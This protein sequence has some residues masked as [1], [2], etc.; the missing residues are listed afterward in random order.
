MSMNGLVS[1]PPQRMN[2]YHQQPVNGFVQDS[3]RGRSYTTNYSQTGAQFAAPQFQQQQQQFPRSS[4]TP[5]RASGSYVGYPS[6]LYQDSVVVPS[7]QPHGPEMAQN[8]AARQQMHQQDERQAQR[9][10]QLKVLQQNRQRRLSSAA[11]DDAPPAQEPSLSSS[12]PAFRIEKPVSKAIPIVRPT[13]ASG[14]NSSR[15]SSP[16]TPSL[17]EGSSQTPRAKSNGSEHGQSPP[18]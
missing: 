15:E 1:P 8:F 6:R 2:P 18:S 5:G 9:Q 13:D 14:S 7:R 4:D 11:E 16:A 12:T 17:A 3:S 10:T